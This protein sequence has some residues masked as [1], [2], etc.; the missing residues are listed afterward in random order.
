MVKTLKM[1]KN[2]QVLQCLNANTKQ[3]YWQRGKHQ[4]N[5]I[6]I[7]ARAETLA[8]HNVKNILIFFIL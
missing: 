1:F 4:N 7:Y 6:K 5:I 3:F 8:V 2:V